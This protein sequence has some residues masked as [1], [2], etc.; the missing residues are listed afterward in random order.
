M[1]EKGSWAYIARQP[2][3][4]ATAAAVDEPKYARENAKSVAVDT[5]GMH[6]RAH[7]D[8]RGIISAILRRMAGKVSAPGAGVR[9]DGA[10]ESTECTDEANERSGA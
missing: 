3:G 1:P 6:R 9:A 10:N 4:C 8:R 7:V 2:C 5:P